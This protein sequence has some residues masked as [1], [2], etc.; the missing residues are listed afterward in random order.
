MKNKSTYPYV[1]TLRHQT[2]S[3]KKYLKEL[4]ARYKNA[5]D[6][7]DN[8]DDLVQSFRGTPCFV[9]NAG[10]ILIKEHK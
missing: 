8:Y 7:L 9:P 3:Y 10:A 1:Y 4:K 5:I 6:N 2:N